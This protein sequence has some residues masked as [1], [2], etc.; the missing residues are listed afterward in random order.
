MIIGFEVYR[1]STNELIE[2]S[3]IK[4]DVGELFKKLTLEDNVFISKVLEVI[5]NTLT[6]YLESTE[7]VTKYG[8]AYVGDFK[9]RSLVFD[10]SETNLTEQELVQEF[11]TKMPN[12]TILYNKTTN[13]TTDEEKVVKL[14]FGTSVKEENTNET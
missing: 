4:V 12:I 7:Y 2:D 8:I 5:Q 1:S 11:N 13:N 14:D 10:D 3:S 6:Q 9:I